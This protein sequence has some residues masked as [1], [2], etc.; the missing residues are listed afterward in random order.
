MQNSIEAV[1][2]DHVARK[3]SILL[4]SSLWRIF[5]R[6]LFDAMQ[7]WKHFVAAAATAALTEEPPA[8]QRRASIIGQRRT[9]IGS[10]SSEYGQENEVSLVEQLR[11]HSQVLRQMGADGGSRSSERRSSIIEQQYNTDDPVAFAAGIMRRR[12]EVDRTTKASLWR[13]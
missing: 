3:N 10:N 4:G 13:R 8:Q 7:R 5:L 9:S 2:K 6:S 11:Q 12:N 1:E